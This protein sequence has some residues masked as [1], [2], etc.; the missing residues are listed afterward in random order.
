MKTDLVGPNA[1]RELLSFEVEARGELALPSEIRQ[2]P[3]EHRYG[4]LQHTRDDI[5]ERPV[6]FW[7]DIVDVRR[8]QADCVIIQDMEI[9][10]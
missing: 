4:L 7:V 8:D 10:G 1:S 2:H 9:G 6:V 5:S 3:L